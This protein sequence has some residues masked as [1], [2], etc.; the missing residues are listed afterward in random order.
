MGRRWIGRGSFFGLCDG[1]LEAGLLFALLA[2]CERV[3][4]FGDEL[5]DLVGVDEE[6]AVLTSFGGLD[7]AVAVETVDDF[8]FAVGVVFAERVHLA[9]V[10]D[11]LAQERGGVGD[12]LRGRGARGRGLREEH[13]RTE[14]QDGKKAKWH[15]V[16]LW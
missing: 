2:G 8:E 7:V 13:S 4:V 10:G 9:L 12:G 14:K 11:D 16:R 6:D 15:R 3:A 5:M 1:A